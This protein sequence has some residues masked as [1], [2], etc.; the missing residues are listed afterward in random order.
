MLD[1]AVFDI[2][3]SSFHTELYPNKINTF[4]LGFGSQQM[5]PEGKLV[6]KNETLNFKVCLVNKKNISKVIC[7]KEKF[8]IN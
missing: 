2:N 4:N 6:N 7:D 8:S 3:K 5:L 1:K